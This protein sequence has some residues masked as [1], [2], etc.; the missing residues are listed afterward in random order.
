[1]LEPVWVRG[2]VV[3]AIHRRQ[4]A[5]HGGQDGIR[6]DGLLASALVGPQNLLA[7]AEPDIGSLAAAYAWSIIRNHPFID[8]NKRTALV[9][10]RTFLKLNGCDLDASREDKV[11]TFL[12]LAAGEISEEDVAL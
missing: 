3:R 4:I 10:A 6:D 1:M 7:Y 5:E 12:R 9:V 8:G 11:G 2:D